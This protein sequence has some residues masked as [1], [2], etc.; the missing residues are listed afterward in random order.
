MINYKEIAFE[1]AIEDSLTNCGG[2]VCGYKVDYDPKV[3]LFPG[4]VL[5]F[6][7]LTQ[8]KEWAYLEAIQKDKAGQT[9]LE[10]LCHALNSDKEGCL[11]VLR[12]G[13]KCFGKLFRMAYFEPASTMNPETTRLYESNL[14]KITRQVKYSPN[15]SN[16]LDLVISLNGIPVATLELK[17][18]LTN[19]T[20]RDA[21]VQY[22]KDRNPTDLIFQF[23]KR[24]LVHFAVDTDEAHMATELKG[25]STVF[26]PFNKGCGLGA[27]NP[28]NPEGC[29]TAYLWE[30]VLERKSFLDILAK[31]VNLEE[32]EREIGGKVFKKERMIFPRYHQLDCVR[33]TIAHAKINGPGQNYLIQ[34]S[35]GSGKSNSIAWLAHRLSCLYNA[36]DEKVFDSVIV[37]TDRLVLDQQLQN[38]VYQF[39]HK[40]G[41]VQKIDKDSTQLAQALLTGTPI[42]VTTM[43]KFPFVTEKV[44]TL[45]KRKYAVIIDEAHS[46]QGGESATDMKGVLGDIEDAQDEIARQM[47]KRGKQTNISFFAF[48]ATPKYKTLEIFGTQGEDGK[49]KAFHLYSMRQAIEEGFILDVLRNYTTYGLYFK[50]IKAIEDDPQFDKRSGARALAR[51]VSLHPYNIAQKTEVMVE[52]F[53][54]H[55]MRKIGGKAKAMLVTSSRLHAVRYKQEFDKYIKEKH[56][57]NIKTLVAFSGVVQDPDMPGVEYTEVGMNGGIREKELPQKFGTSDYQVLLVADKYQTGFDQPLLHTMYV[58]KRLSGIQAV[59]TLSRLNRTCEGKED[60]FILDFVNDTEEILSSFQSFYE[61]TGI[62]DRTQPRLLYEQL[63]KIMNKKIIYEEDID[64]L[65]SIYFQTKYVLSRIDHAKINAIIDPTIRRFSD[66]KAEEKPDFKKTLIAFKNLYAFMSQIIPFQDQDLEKL[67]VFVR[68]LI[69]KLQ[70]EHDP[71]PKFDDEVAF[72]YYRLEK[73]HDGTI[74]LEKNSDIAI[75]GPSETGSGKSNKNLVELSVLINLLN[76]KFGTQFKPGDQLFFDSIREDALSNEKVVKA[77]NANSL[78]NFEFMFKKEL[79][80]IFYERMEQNEEITLRFM[81]EEKFRDILSKYFSKEVYSKANEISI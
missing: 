73:I 75:D 16:E 80:R 33:K 48:T 2:Y 41:V 35:A 78:D 39:E 17:N 15:N 1:Q 76:E 26:L 9:L 6:V 71:F 12:H 69:P 37:V 40:Q 14:L 45:E 27:G 50:L 53:I 55:T 51:F 30:E 54:H 36:K 11:S 70:I 63:A 61:V 10:D 66:L 52:H 74:E 13:F 34:H 32:E 57:D 21:V 47:A 22:K 44:G 79:E 31:F 43:Q 81:S 56:Y 68:F 20:W 46:S 64:R 58:D 65:S 7:K 23:R 25:T 42:V 3:A 18:P 67:Y 5:E 59:Q 29:K 62:G 38:T 77:A 24:A 19:Q 49:P 8:P 4:D 60:N 28:D 72:K